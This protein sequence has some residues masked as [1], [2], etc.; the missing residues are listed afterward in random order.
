MLGG[1]FLQFR[2]VVRHI[3]LI[4]LPTLFA[5]AD[6]VPVIL[7]PVFLLLFDVKLDQALARLDPVFQFTLLQVGAKLSD[8]FSHCFLVHVVIGKVTCLQNVE[9]FAGYVNL[10][11]TLVKRMRLVS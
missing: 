11:E 8:R 2:L 4:L 10:K 1:E 7:I 9:C 6:H 3:R 5:V